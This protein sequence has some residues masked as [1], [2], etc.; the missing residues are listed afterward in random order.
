MQFS[1]SMSIGRT[2]FT[3][4]R[5]INELED[6]LSLWWVDNHYIIIVQQFKEWLGSY[7]NISW[8]EHSPTSCKSKVHMYEFFTIVSRTK[9]SFLLNNFQLVFVP[10]R[11][12]WVMCVFTSLFMFCLVLFSSEAPFVGVEY[13]YECIMNYH[14]ENTSLPGSPEQLVQTVQLQCWKN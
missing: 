12:W 8:L 6:L 2:Y 13:I 3:L 4:P 10:W 14:S 11:L 5:S 1:F 9:N 7:W